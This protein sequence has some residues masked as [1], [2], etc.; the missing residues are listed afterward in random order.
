MCILYDKCS[1]FLAI[2]DCKPHVKSGLKKK[3]LN[4]TRCYGMGSTSWTLVTGS[5]KDFQWIQIFVNWK[6]RV[7]LVNYTCSKE[8]RLG[9]GGGA[10]VRRWVGQVRHCCVSIREKTLFRQQTGPSCFGS[11]RFRF[12]RTDLRSL[13]LIKHIVITIGDLRV[14]F[15]LC[16]KASPNAKPFIWKL[17]LFTC[18]WTKIGVWIKLISIWKASH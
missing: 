6:T 18:K 3:S 2:V 16:F 12:D 1:C 5:W 11:V 4:S 8:G 13:R 10:H 14:V 15:R 9:R 7:R 17:V